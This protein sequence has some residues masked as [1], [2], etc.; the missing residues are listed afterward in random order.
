MTATAT[1]SV[2]TVVTTDNIHALPAGSVIACD[3]KT[4]LTRR[5]NGWTHPGLYDLRY[6]DE[7]ITGS[8]WRFTVLRVSWTAGAQ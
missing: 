2:G 1:V 6:T 5:D 7:A 3:H 8:P 4:P